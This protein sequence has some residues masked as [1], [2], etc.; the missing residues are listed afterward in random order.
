MRARYTYD[1][2]NNCIDITEIPPTTT[3]E[4]IMDKVVDLVKAGKIREIADMR[5]EDAAPPCLVDL[6]QFPFVVNDIAASWEVGGF[7]GL[8]QVV[9]GVAQDSDRG[10]ADLRKVKRADR[11]SHPNC[12]H[13]KLLYTMYKMGLL[14]GARTKSANVVGQTMRLNPHGDS[15]IYDNE[16]IPTAMPTLAFTRTDGKVTGS[17]VGSFMVLS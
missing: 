2:A 6:T 10:F 17:R 13:R 5:D 14:T 7:E 15:A 3:V 11:R 1:K 12:S 4:A 9:I 16:A 8:S